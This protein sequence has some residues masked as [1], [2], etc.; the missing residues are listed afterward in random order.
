VTQHHHFGTS[1][2]L[3]GV[4]PITHCRAWSRFSARHSPLAL[5]VPGVVVC[6]EAKVLSH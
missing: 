4:H 3:G 2:P 1:M 5:V 6:L